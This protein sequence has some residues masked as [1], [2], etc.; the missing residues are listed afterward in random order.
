MFT[1]QNLILLGYIV[2]AIIILILNSYLTHYQNNN[3]RNM[4]DEAIEHALLVSKTS[5][6]WSAVNV[7]LGSYLAYLLYRVNGSSSSSSNTVRANSYNPNDVS[8]NAYGMH[9]EEDSTTYRRFSNPV[10][11]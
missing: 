8:N 4:D 1:L 7:I 11:N 2:V 10:S 6:F 3:K 9:R 5:T